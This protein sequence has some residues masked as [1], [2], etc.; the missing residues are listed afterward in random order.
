MGYHVEKTTKTKSNEHM[1]FRF[2]KA[3]KEHKNLTQSKNTINKLINKC[4]HNARNSSDNLLS[5]R[6][7]NHLGRCL[8][9]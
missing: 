5:Y 9:Q 1:K 8:L 2:T 4:A 7:D 3:H 6:S